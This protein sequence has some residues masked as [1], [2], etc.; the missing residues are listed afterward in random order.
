MPCFKILLLKLLYIIAQVCLTPV[1]LQDFDS[2]FYNQKYFK[3]SFASSLFGAP[4][5]LKGKGQ[6]FPS[7]GVKRID[8]TLRYT[9]L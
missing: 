5:S 2:L 9:F 3:A 6:I 1:I 7:K 8:C 4:Y